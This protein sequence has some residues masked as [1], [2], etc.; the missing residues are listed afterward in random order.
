MSGREARSHVVVRTGPAWP[1]GAAPVTDWPRLAE[2]GGRPAL[3]LALA[4]RAGGRGVLEGGACGRAEPRDGCLST[5]A[6][7]VAALVDEVDDVVA[8]RA[9][10][11]ESLH[12]DLEHDGD[13]VV[14]SLRPKA[15]LPRQGPAEASCSPR[16]TLSTQATPHPE[17]RPASANRPLGPCRPDTP[18]FVSTYPAASVNEDWCGTIAELGGGAGLGAAG[19]TPGIEMPAALDVMYMVNL[20]AWPVE[21]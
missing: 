9:P 20:P 12:D 11:L 17:L 21:G 10:A 13:K 5:R 7:A 16:T 4:G 14:L 1:A 8:A 18:A 2:A 3:A 15:A 6:D 19:T